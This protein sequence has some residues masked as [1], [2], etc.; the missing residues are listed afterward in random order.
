LRNFLK[1][2]IKKVVRGLKTLLTLTLLLNWFA[3]VAHC[4]LAKTGFFHESGS[5]ASAGCPSDSES[6]GHADSRVCDWV[7]SGGLQAV[8]IRVIAPEALAIELAPLFTTDAC[9]E[10][11]SLKAGCLIEWSVAPPELVHTFQFVLRTAL[12]ARAPSLA[13]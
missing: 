10:Q 11:L 2:S 1:T 6:S 3:C 8:D 5:H 4:Q 7:M 9:D 13:S 12:P